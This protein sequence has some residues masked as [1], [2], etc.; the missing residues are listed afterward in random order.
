MSTSGRV[1]LFCTAGLVA[2]ILSGLLFVGRTPR[3]TTSELPDG[4]RAQLDA[5]IV[6]I[7]ESDP[8]FDDPAQMLGSTVCAASVFGVAPRTARTADDV[9]TAYAWVLCKWP[10]ENSAVSMPVAV[11]FGSRPSYVAPREGE[12]AYSDSIRA[13]FPRELQARA[14]TPSAQDRAA[15]DEVDRRIAAR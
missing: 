10:A 7:L 5:R 2:A 11:H 4:V 13:I 9:Q 6:T 12:G 1:W 14:F 15:M 8:G 3:T